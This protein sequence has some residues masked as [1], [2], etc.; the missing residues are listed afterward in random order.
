RVINLSLLNTDWYIDQMAR[1]A[2]DSDPAP[3]SL[4]SEQYIQGTRDYLPIIDKNKKDVYVD[5]KAIMNF[6]SDPKNG[7]MFSG[8]KTMNYI[9]TT[10]FSLK[11]DKEKVLAQGI[12]PENKKD[13]ILDELTWVIDKNYI[14][15]KDMM[16]LD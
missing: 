16:I 11:V 13:Q 4:S 1:K 9:P 8:N 2:Y 14:L 5:V 3:F 12:V 6:V 15:K 10:K 7:A